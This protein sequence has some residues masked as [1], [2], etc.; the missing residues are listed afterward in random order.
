MVMA[1]AWAKEQDQLDHNVKWY[2]ENGIGVM[3]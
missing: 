1:I 3:F 2:Q